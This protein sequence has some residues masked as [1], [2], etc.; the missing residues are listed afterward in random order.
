MEKNENKRLTDK[1]IEA[2]RTSALEMEKF[3]VKMALG[4]SEA[5]E[6][7][8][9]IKKKLNLFLHDA[10]HKIK[11]GKETVEDVH[12]KLD[13]LLV[14]LNLGKAE[15]IEAFNEQKKELL[16]A[17]HE[18]EVKIKSNEKLKKAYAFVLVE[19]ETFKIQLTM[20]ERK[21]NKKF[22]KTDS[23][24]KKGKD[25]FLEMIEKLKVKYGLK[26]ET[27]WE[28]FQNEVSDAFQNFK[29]AFN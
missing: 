10:K 14:K 1:I 3:Q 29:K 5:K 17:I 7:Y 2:L 12:S 13:Q 8:E 15:T 22:A 4:T 21:F 25:Y 11:T 24:F 9:D 27:K 20:L 18:L 16:N 23:S 26:K 28:Q 19:I 6:S